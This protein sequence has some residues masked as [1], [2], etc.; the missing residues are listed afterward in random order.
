MYIFIDESGSFAKA[1]KGDS[2]NVVAAYM[3]PEAEIARMENALSELK[4]TAGVDQ[5]K[6]IK[7]R[8]L[9]ELQY[10]T[11]LVGLSRLEGVLF[12]AATDASQSNVSDILQHRNNQ[13]ESITKH[14]HLMQHEGGRQALLKLSDKVQR[15]SPQ[16]YIQLQCQV[17]LMYSV[18]RSGVLYF[19]QRRPEELGSFRWRIDQKHE[20]RT[21]YEIVFQAITPALLQSISLEKPMML[22]NG[23]DYS[24]FKRFDFAEGEAPDYLKTTYGMDIDISNT[25]NIGKLV[26][27]DIRFVDSR[28]EVG[29]QVADLLASGMRRCLRMGFQNNVGIARILG[30]L[31]VQGEMQSPP[32]QLLGFTEDDVATSRETTRLVQNMSVCSR[33]MRV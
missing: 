5:D 16:L 17:M 22:L 3:T 20:R 19:V 28:Q 30:E 7:L 18:V 4:R 24:A 33:A 9:S 26:H 6:E 12:A 10:A 1:T 21:E 14:V 27:E 13:A 31:L 25:T 23:A 2:W 29:I 15:L 32:L 11:L 8:D